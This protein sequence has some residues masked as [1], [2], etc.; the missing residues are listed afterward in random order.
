MN[1]IER[2]WKGKPP[3]LIMAS[4]FLSHWAELE[5]IRGDIRLPFQRQKKVAWPS[6]LFKPETVNMRWNYTET[7]LSANLLAQAKIMQTDVKERSI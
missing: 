4:P 3:L 6:E 1:Y 7:K 2:P 5:N